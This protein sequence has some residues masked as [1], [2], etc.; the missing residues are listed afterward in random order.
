MEAKKYKVN[1]LQKIKQNYQFFYFFYYYDLTNK[2]MIVLKKRMKTLESNIFILN[3]N[4]IHTIFLNLQNQGTILMIYGN[5]ELHLIQFKKLKFICLLFKNKI[6]SNL[7][8][9]QITKQ[10]PPLYNLITYPI[11]RFF[12]ILK[13]INSWR[14]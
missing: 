2:E 10:Y 5:S 7:K 14:L 4:L 11:F 9:K 6:Y 12:Y 1:Q 3:K 13:S 8:I